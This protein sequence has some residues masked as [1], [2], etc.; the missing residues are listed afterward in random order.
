MSPRLLHLLY[1]IVGTSRFSISDRAYFHY[2][3]SKMYYFSIFG[4]NTKDNDSLSIK[5]NFTCYIPFMLECQTKYFTITTI[6]TRF[7]LPKCL[8]HLPGDT[9]RLRKRCDRSGRF[10]E[11]T[12]G[13]SEN[14]TRTPYS[15]I[16]V[17]F[18]K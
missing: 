1:K 15:I 14:V 5:T 4:Q 11:F 3:Q 12:S 13:S 8:F 2:I 6:S 17:S 7:I 9:R 18:P 16:L 10:E